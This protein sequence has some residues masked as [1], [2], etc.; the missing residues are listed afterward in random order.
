MQLSR[1]VQLPRSSRHPDTLGVDTQGSVL[2]VLL[3]DVLV[4]VL[5]VVVRVVGALV[6]LVAPG[7]VDVVVSTT[8]DSG[9]P[10]CASEQAGFLSSSPAIRATR[11][12][13]AGSAQWANGKT[14]MSQSVGISHRG[15]RGST[16]MHPS[17]NP[18]PIAY[19]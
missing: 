6:L 4:E 8:S 7:S 9:S 5:E 10:Q 2:V 1:I 14:A 16:Q 18:T 13:L 19:A 17:K 11:H 3:D 12:V 15:A